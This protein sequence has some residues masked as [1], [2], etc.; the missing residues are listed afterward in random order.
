MKEI[1]KIVKGYKIERTIGTRGYY[2]VTLKEGKNFRKFLSFR[3]AK[4]AERY[5]TEC[6]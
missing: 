2:E 4:Q 5:I 1:V 3:S 6:L